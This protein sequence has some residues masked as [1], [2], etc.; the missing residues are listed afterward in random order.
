MTVTD[1]FKDDSAY[2]AIRAL[3]GLEQ[4]AIMLEK[5]APDVFPEVNE[6]GQKHFGR[7]MME[8]AAQAIREAWAQ[9]IKDA[10][11]SQRAE[12]VAELDGTRDAF[13]S[14]IAAIER[15]GFQVFHDISDNTYSVRPRE[16]ED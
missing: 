7:V 13:R 11:N 16:T 10:E 5:W 12:H 14:L 2:A 1:K 6:Q 9:A 3:R 15:E 8:S 4:T